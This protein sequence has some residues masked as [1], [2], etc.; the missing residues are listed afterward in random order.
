MQDVIGQ[1]SVMDQESWYG[2]LSKPKS[3]FAW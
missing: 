1:L 3:Q 2:W